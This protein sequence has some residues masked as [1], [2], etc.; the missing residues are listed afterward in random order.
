MLQYTTI[1]GDRDNARFGLIVHHTDGDREWAY[2][3]ASHIG[4]LD[5]AHDCAPQEGWLIVDMM[6][7]W[8][9]VFAAEK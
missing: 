6:K 7:D 4:Q 2:D 9:R 5:K 3:R 8:K 1:T